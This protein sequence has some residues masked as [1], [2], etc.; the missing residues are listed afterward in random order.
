VILAR[1]IVR[2]EAFH[3]DITLIIGCKRNGLLTIL[4]IAARTGVR[5]GKSDR[6]RL[7]RRSVLLFYPN[8]KISLRTS[9]HRIDRALTFHQQN[10][11][12]LGDGGEYQQAHPKEYS[13]R[14]LLIAIPSPDW[15]L[16]CI[17]R[18]HGREC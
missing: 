10:F 8:C 5:Q 6:N 9:F 3:S 18:R 12:V 1:L 7:S 14:L 13:H 2:P 11:H 15:R 16:A 17:I 4:E